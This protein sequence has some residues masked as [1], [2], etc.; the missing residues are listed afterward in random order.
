MA[1][2]VQGD[3]VDAGMLGDLLEG[4][5][6]EPVL[7]DGGFDSGAERA[8]GTHG[9]SVAARCCRCNIWL[10]ACLI[11]VPI[12]AM[13]RSTHAAELSGNVSERSADRWF[14]SATCPSCSSVSAGGH[15]GW[16]RRVHPSRRCSG[17]CS[18]PSAARSPP[19]G[20]PPAGRELEPPGRAAQ[21]RRSPALVESLQIGSLLTLPVMVGWFGLRGVAVGL[22]VRDPSVGRR[23]GAR[24]PGSPWV[25]GRAHGPGAVALP[26]VH[27]RATGSTGS[28]G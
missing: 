27:H 1:A 9:S 26:M 21:P 24:R 23:A 7:V 25:I 10:H 17:C 16:R 13:R 14:V 2:A 8:V 22:A 18:S 12:R 11:Y 15:H 20:S 6:V 28:T 5:G 3:P 4:D 19:S